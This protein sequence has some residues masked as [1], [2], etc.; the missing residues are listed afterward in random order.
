MTDIMKLSEQV[1]SL[2][3]HWLPLYYDSLL[4]TEILDPF[5]EVLDVNMLRSAHADCVTFDGV[6]EVRLRTT[7]VKK[8]KKFSHGTSWVG[9]V[10]ARYDTATTAVLL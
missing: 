8:Q 1:V 3:V 10:P 2:R 6:R 7:E 4:L 5:G 9:S